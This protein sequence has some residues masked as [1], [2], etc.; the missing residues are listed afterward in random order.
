[1]KPI[2]RTYSIN[3]YK[4]KE[5]IQ[6]VFECDDLKNIHHLRKDLFPDKNVL[7]KPWPLNENTTKFHQEFYSKLDNDWDDIKNSY[8]LFIKNE[9]KPLFNEEFL[10]QKFPTFR[11]NLPELKSVNKWHYDSDEN[12]RHPDGEI[13]FH[14]GITDCFDTNAIWVESEP[15]KEDFKPINVKYGEFA[16]FNGNKCT[17]GN[18]TNKTEVTR[19]SF[20]FRVLPISKY[21]AGKNKTSVTIN[22]KFEEGGYYKKYV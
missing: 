20:D 14:I 11:V 9:I 12:H 21:K 22:N 7:S 8:E 15:R 17:H 16:E 13:N 4:W 3:K 5:M 10:Y 1:M 19:I 6:D 2:I 18:K